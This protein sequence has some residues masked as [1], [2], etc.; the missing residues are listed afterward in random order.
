MLL[1]V[2]VQLNVKSAYSHDLTAEKAV[3]MTDQ[4]DPILA[5]RDSVL[6]YFSSASG[7][8]SDMRGD[9]LH[10]TF[11][12]DEKQKKGMRFSVFRKGK[13]FYHPI[14]KVPIGDIEESIGRIEIR[15]IEADGYR[16]KVI[17]GSPQIGDIVRITSSRIKLAFFQDKKA[18]WEYSEAFYNAL[19]DSGRFELVE[20]YASS[21]KAQELSALAKD[22]GAEAVVFFSTPTMN[23][24]IFVKAKLYWS[25]DAVGFA[26]VAKM[27]KHD[28]QKITAEDEF[29][30]IPSGGEIPWGNFEITNGKFLAMGDVNGN[31]E[32]ELVVSDGTGLRIYSYKNEPREIWF[33]KGSSREEHLSLDVLDSNDNGTAEIFVTSL[34]DDK[35]R[36]Y[37]LEYNP[38]EGYK[39]LW[40]KARYAFRVIDETLFMQ[41]FSPGKSF[42]GP[43]YKSIWKEGRYQT[44]TPVELPQGVD[45]YGFTFIDWRKNNNK[46]IIGFDDKGYLNLYRN[47]VLIWQS[48]DSYIKFEEAKHNNT[49]SFSDS[50]PSATN[51]VKK[52]LLKGRLITVNT[53]RGQEI[54]V[55]KRV[56][57]LSMVPGLGYGKADVYSFWWDG[58]MMNENLI[59]SGIKG[60]VTDYWLERDN[61]LIIARLNLV[62]YVSKAVSGN[63]NRGSILYYYVL[64]ER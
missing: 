32:R 42:V 54:L 11:E 45:I 39:K 27:V 38:A 49:E 52:L 7:Q 13:P 57:Y 61:L 64:G 9:S 16:G 36:S 17:T 56:H 19:K 12:G 41:E 6:S 59:L 14:T 3:S 30:P 40:S 35:M 37:V 18:S 20:S 23:Q 60:M 25:E 31:G 10:I 29:I 8:I 63:F 55:I 43:V 51:Y 33:L 2:S 15:E 44:G 1:N 34:V 58:T 5:L 24:N 21:Y 26:E 22:H 47:N 62:G 50:L 48:K 46:D 53:E 4:E 28:T